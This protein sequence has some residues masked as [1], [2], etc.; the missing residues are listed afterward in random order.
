MSLPVTAKVPF[1]GDHNPEQWPEDVWKQD[2]RLFDSARID[3]LTGDRALT[4]SALRL[5]AYGVVVVR[6]DG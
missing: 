4:G 6:E 1:G 3:L 5:P 2:H